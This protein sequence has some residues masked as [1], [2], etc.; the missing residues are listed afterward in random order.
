MALIIAR[1]DTGDDPVRT[2]GVG[3]PGVPVQTT[4]TLDGSGDPSPKSTDVK[5]FYLVA[6]GARYY[7]DPTISFVEEQTGIDYKVSHDNS[8]WVNTYTFAS[9]DALSEDQNTIFYVKAEVVNDGSGTQPGT[10]TYTGAKMRLE[11]T[12][13]DHDPTI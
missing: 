5:T 10:G 11:A 9:M 1:V 4:V 3:A 7:E 6:D 8:T 12:E 13:Y 2:G